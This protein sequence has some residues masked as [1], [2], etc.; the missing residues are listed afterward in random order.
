MQT[1]KKYL[2]ELTYKIIGCAFEVHKQIGPGL[3]ESVY[4]KCFLK[5]L[6]LQELAYQNQVWVHWNTEA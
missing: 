1:T 2:N 6:Q 3:L 5:E 4:E